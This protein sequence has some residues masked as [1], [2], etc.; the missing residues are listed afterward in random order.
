MSGASIAKKIAKGYGKAGKKLGYKFV[1]YR[2]DDYVQP[3][4][5]RNIAGEVTCAY[6]YD[7]AFEGQPSAAF[8]PMMLYVNSTNLQEG[9]ILHSDE[10]GVTLTLVAKFD[11]RAPVGI[12]T[13]Q[14]VSISRT[15]YSTT[16]GFGPKAELVYT[17]VPAKVLQVAS[18]TT[19]NMQPAASN[20][21]GAHPV[22]G[23]WTWLPES[24]KLLP[25]DTIVFADG[26]KGIIQSIEINQLGYHLKVLEVK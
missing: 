2:S 26:T 16:G 7:K 13:N 1:L 22:Y 11:M 3:V 24:C 14:K 17:D 5:D 9:D 18:S 25:N 8:Q 21:K 19:G 23:V 12:E 15:T 10:L 6:S 4:Q 20:L